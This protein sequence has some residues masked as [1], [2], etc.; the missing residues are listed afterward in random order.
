ML[1]IRQAKLLKWI[2]DETSPVRSVSRW[3][4][5][6]ER[7]KLEDLNMNVLRQKH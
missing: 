2:L 4:L 5:L 3:T 6:T 1:L 7:H